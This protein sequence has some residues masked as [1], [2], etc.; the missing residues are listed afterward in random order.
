VAADLSDHPSIKGNTRALGT[1]T[2]IING[3][4]SIIA[5]FGLLII[6]PLQ[7]AYGWSAVWILLI[8][9]TIIGKHHHL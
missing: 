9:N 2:G 4:G 8:I 1:V 5:A 3:S 7:N 6:G